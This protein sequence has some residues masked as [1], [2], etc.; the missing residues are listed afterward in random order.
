MNYPSIKPRF[1]FMRIVHHWI[2]LTATFLA[3]FLGCYLLLDYTIGLLPVVHSWMLGPIAGRSVVF[4]VLVLVFIIRYVK[5][6]S[7]YSR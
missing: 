5:F 6:R 7:P 3:V 1:A 2:S 4:A